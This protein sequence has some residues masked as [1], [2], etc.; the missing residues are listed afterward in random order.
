MNFSWW[1]KIQKPTETRKVIL[2]IKFTLISRNELFISI[3]SLPFSSK[4]SSLRK[5]TNKNLPLVSCFVK[6]N[7]C[8]QLAEIRL[9]HQLGSI[10]AK[11]LA[12]T[13]GN[14]WR[15]ALKQGRHLF[16]SKRIIGMKFQNFDL[17]SFPNKNK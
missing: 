9:P 5:V 13:C 7:F 14:H 11:W 16:Q 3:Q 15:A 1:Y 4:L 17:F 10:Y 8:W 2:K 12:L 6:S